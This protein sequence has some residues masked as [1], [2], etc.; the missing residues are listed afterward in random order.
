MNGIISSHQ[1]C[2]GAVARGEGLREYEHSTGRVSN[3]HP[4]SLLRLS[5]SRVTRQEKIQKGKKAKDK[6][7]KLEKKKPERGNADQGANDRVVGSRS[8]HREHRDHRPLLPT[9]NHARM[10][11]ST[12]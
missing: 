2:L 8:G 11:L 7:G 3:T 6:K 1:K 9:D 12:P 5:N 10:R 4:N